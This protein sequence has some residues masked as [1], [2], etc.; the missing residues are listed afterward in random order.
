MHQ[1]TTSRLINVVFSAACYR[2]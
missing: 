2:L 1:E